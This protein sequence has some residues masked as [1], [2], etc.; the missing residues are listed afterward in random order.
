MVDLISL[1]TSTKLQAD[2]LRAI[3]LESEMPWN[4]DSEQKDGQ[5]S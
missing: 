5:S 2:L 1:Y 3:F 4:A